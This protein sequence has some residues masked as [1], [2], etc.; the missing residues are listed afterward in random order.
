[1]VEAV[2]VESVSHA[3]IPAKQ[4]NLQGI[5]RKQALHWAID[6]QINEQLQYIAGQIPYATEQGIFWSEQGISGP[7]QGISFPILLYGFSN[8]MHRVV[9]DWPATHMT[10]LIVIPH[11]FW[12]HSPS[13]ATA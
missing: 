10:Q 8:A 5:S 3:P 4:G 7:K 1:M 9:P 13:D 11:V 6:G 12:K 2:L